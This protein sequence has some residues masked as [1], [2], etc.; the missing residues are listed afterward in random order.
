VAIPSETI[1]QIAAGNDIV[2]VI[3]SYFPL[4]R[5]GANFRALCPFHQ[6]KTP[7]FMVSPSRQTF[8]CF[9]CGAGG[10]VF[11]FVMDYEHVD[12]PAAVR[13]L[14]ARAGITIVEKRGAADEDRQYETRRKLLKLH[15]EAAEWF[16]ENLTKREIGEPARKYLKQRGITGE[17]AKRWQLGYAPDEWDAFGSWARGQ[18]YDARELVASGLIKT[19]DDDQT[20]NLKPQTS[21]DRFRGRIMF[22][23]CNDVGEVIAFSGRLLK[24][25]EGAAKYLNSPETPLF[26][27]GNVLFGL[28]KSKRA[29]IEANS[30]IVCE[31]QL[32]LISLFEAGITNVVAPQGTAFTENQAR[33]LKRYVKEVVL[34]YDSDRAGEKAAEKS[35][36]PLLRLVADTAWYNALY[37][38]FYVRIAEMPAGKDPDALIREGGADAFRERITN[39]QDF[40]DYWIDRQSRKADLS[41]LKARIELAASLASTV[42]EIHDPMYR[43]EVEHKVATRLSIPVSEFRALIKKPSI[44]PV[45]TGPEQVDV[46]RGHDV[47]M[48]S[49]LALRDE[50]SRDFLLEQNWRE[51]LEETPGADLLTRI[52]ESEVGPNDPASLNAFM[53]KLSTQ[54]EG[55]VS[56]W[57]MQKIPGN[58]VEVTESWWNGLQRA[59]FGRRL[60]VAKN[61][62]K[63]PGLTAGEVLNLQKQILDL[64]EQL[65]EFCRPVGGGD[66]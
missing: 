19:K 23:I 21:Y 65:H 9:G 8:H 64:Q 57:L 47:A 46:V 24:D 40:F 20:S 29:L 4:K 2:E 37:D 60:E 52:L 25:E 13:K 30:A 53:S 34:C 66:A 5:A 49:M 17:I 54:D 41:S 45:S 28:H 44:A 58:A 11:R 42:S 38:H 43:G 26:R 1:E 63:D 16:H 6:E 55:L 48:I 59:V 22:P 10:S 3:G 56:A 39:A 27:K 33:V 18:G 62:I 50:W 31:G 35:L 14:A 32:D 15:A 12:F 51:V 7:S 36:S 61:R